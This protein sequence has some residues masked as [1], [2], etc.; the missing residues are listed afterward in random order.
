VVFTEDRW[1]V[2]HSVECRLSG[3]MHECGHH[4][5]VARITAEFDPE[6]AGRWRIA[7]IDSDGLPDLVRADPTGDTQPN[8]SLPDGARGATP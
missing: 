2:E 1:T 7:S 6:M 4:A 3:R 8:A 5:A